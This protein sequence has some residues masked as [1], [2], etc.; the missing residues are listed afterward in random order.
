[1][2]G[3]FQVRIAVLTVLAACAGCGKVRI[4]VSSDVESEPTERR[5]DALVSVRDCAVEAGYA[6][7]QRVARTGAPELHVLGVYESADHAFGVHTRGEAVVEVR[8][9]VPMVLVLSAYEATHW[10]IRAADQTEIEQV[11]LNGYYQQTASVAPEV[12]VID[13]SDFASGKPMLS[14]CGYGDDEGGCDTRSLIH[15]AEQ[16]TGQALTSFTGCYHAS[17]FLIDDEPNDT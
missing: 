8:R 3:Q 2:F 5:A 10:T 15:G 1:M 13:R 7:V 12:E 6:V 4:G 11:I 9:S 16:L 17:S 14:D